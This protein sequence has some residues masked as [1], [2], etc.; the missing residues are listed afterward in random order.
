M[1]R[2]VA[3]AALALLAG[4]STTTNIYEVVTPDGATESSTAH[5]GED[6]A[7][8]V[9]A[10]VVDAGSLEGGSQADAGSDAPAPEGSN[11]S[12]S[13]DAT[14]DEGGG[15]DASAS[16]ATESGLP[17]PTMF[18]DSACKAGFYE[19]MFTGTYSSH[20][21]V[22]GIDIPVSGNVQLTLDQEGSSNQQC[23]IDVQGEGVTTESCSDVF[24]LSGGTIQGILDGLFPY[25]CTLT[26]TLDC[27]TESL[28]N[29]WMECTY[30]AIGV[31]LDGGTPPGD[32]LANCTGA[33]GNFAGPLTASYDTSTL[34]F[35][36]GTWNGSERLC[37][38]IAGTSTATCNDG[39]SPGPE[40]GPASDYLVLDGGYGLNAN[41]GGAGSWSATCL[42]C[43]HD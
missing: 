11:D 28:D 24:S 29:G 41:F 21:T 43:D 9:Q 18:S 5:S 22:V 2:R 12:G 17:P 35:T 15:S 26:G 25:F 38:G 4:C 33:G 34:S 7:E 10:P 1:D 8:D 14:I 3:R 20:I 31:I 39:G 23:T 19:G 6:A 16:D 30:C 36:S 27:A 40:G 42:N 32:P 37:D 13:L